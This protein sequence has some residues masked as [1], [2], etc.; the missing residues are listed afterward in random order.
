MPVPKNGGMVS[1][2]PALRAPARIARLLFVAVVAVAI[3]APLTPATAAPA[4][5]PGSAPAVVGHP[6]ALGFL[7]GPDVSSW[8]HPNGAPI[9]WG[10]VAAAGNSFAFVKATEGPT[11]V[12]GSFYTN[13][14]FAGDF[15]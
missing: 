6:D 14:Y 10:Q 13:P 1:P 4:A 5:P 2:V 8:N 7:T 9:S 15:G 12:G 3:V 11:T